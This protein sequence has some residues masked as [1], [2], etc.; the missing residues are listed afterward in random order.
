MF[1]ETS[2]H[3]LFTLGVRD[4]CPITHVELLNNAEGP[5]DP[6]DEFYTQFL[7]A[8]RTTN[9]IEFNTGFNILFGEYEKSYTFKIKTTTFGGISATKQIELIVGCF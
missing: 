1:D 9:A 4:K 7:L 3:P 5:F 2:I 6:L 8:T